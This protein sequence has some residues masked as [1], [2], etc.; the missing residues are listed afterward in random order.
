[1][2][3]AIRWMIGIMFASLLMVGIPGATAQAQDQQCFV[4]TNQC[5]G[6]RIRSFWEANGGLM[7]FGFPITPQRLEQIDGK[8]V[9]VQ[10]FE[11]ARLELHPENPAPYD[12]LL[13]RLG[14]ERLAQRGQDWTTF[15]TSPNEVRNDCTY[16]A[17]TGH[18]VCAAMRF[19]WASR[20]I[21]MDGV[22]GFSFAESLAMLGLP[23]DE[24]RV[25]QIEGKPVQVQWFERGRLEFHPENQPP[26]NIL[27]GLVGREVLDNQPSSP[28]A[29]PTGRILF[30]DSD[31]VT[32]KR[33]NPNGSGIETLFTIT[34]QPSE[35]VASLSADSSGANVLYGVY[36]DQGVR[37]MLV[38]GGVARNLG[39]F[40]SRPRWSPSGNALLMQ[41][42]G[43][44]NQEGAVFLYDIATGLNVELPIR[45]TPDWFPDG[46]RIIYVNH[47]SNGNIIAANVSVYDVSA[48]TS[49][50]LTTFPETGADV[51]AI[52]EAHVLP[53]GQH[54]VFYGGQSKN[55]GASGNGMEWWS[56]PVGGG[57]LQPFGQPGGNGVL[58]YTTSANGEWLAY[59]T[60]M[61]VSACASVGSITVH[62]SDVRGGISMNVPLPSPGGKAYVLVRGLAW[63]PNSNYLALG[64]ESYRCESAASGQETVG[65]PLYVWNV[66]LANQNGA[67]LTKIADGAFPVWVR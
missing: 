67:T 30:L 18:F 17:A 25:E 44:N 28:V 47:T 9:Q 27:G 7:T 29:A 54:V 39:T 65:V 10:W 52:Q 33:V 34:K 40:A 3:W 15:P 58:D 56:I 14:V 21:E 57:I 41:G 66:R 19:G 6:G 32:V 26:Y 42:Y 49:T 63:E 23:L 12:V 64:V 20:G 62:T 11:R 46:N 37:Y 36:S 51:W 24:A 2:E 8:P 16:F 38:N 48:R 50:R 5:I 22:R 61:H 59:G 4:E 60:Q 55:L 1:M 43:Q 53:D 35:D 13:G 31:G 45:G